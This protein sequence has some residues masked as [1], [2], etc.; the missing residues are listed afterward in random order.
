MGMNHQLLFSDNEWIFGWF[1]VIGLL[2]FEAW[3]E[4][5]GKLIERFYEG[6][7]L[8]RWLVAYVLVMATVILGSYGV[9]VLDKQFIYFQF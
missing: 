7:G 5:R 2:S 8:K 3:Q 6:P 9:Y 4:Y 1:L